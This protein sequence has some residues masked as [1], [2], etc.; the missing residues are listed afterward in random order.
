MGQRRVRG[1]PKGVL[2][3][4]RAGN[5]AVAALDGPEAVRF[6]GEDRLD[7]GLTVLAVNGPWMV[8]LPPPANPVDDLLHFAGGALRSLSLLAHP[9]QKRVVVRTSHANENGVLP[10]DG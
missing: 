4:P 2:Q 9:R 6:R 8:R 10:F 3:S 1:A 5:W 7:Q